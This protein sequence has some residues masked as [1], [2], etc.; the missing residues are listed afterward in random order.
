[1]Q[2]LW[3][4]GE[5]DG[6]AEHMTDDPLQHPEHQVLLQ[7]AVGDFQVSNLTAEIEARSIGASIYQPAL[8][9]GRHWDVDRS[10]TCLPSAHSRLAA[11]RRWSTTT[12]DRSI[13]S[14]MR[15]RTP[16][17]GWNAATPIRRRARV[18][19]PRSRRRPTQRPSRVPMD[20]P[21][22]S[23]A[24]LGWAAARDGLAAAEWIHRCVHGGLNGPAVLRQRLDRSLA[25]GRAFWR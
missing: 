25:R 23:A 8:D 14:T 2:L 9:P 21:R 1:M 24:V 17:P 3:D 10:S 22:V 6:Y 19:G 11:R 7:A 12:A 18:R 13:G 16:R 20:H 15:P 4:R 5:A